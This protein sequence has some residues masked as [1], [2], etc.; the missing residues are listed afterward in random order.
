MRALSRRAPQRDHLVKQGSRTVRVFLVVREAVHEGDK[1][2]ADLLNCVACA[3]LLWLTIIQLEN[4]V[5][6]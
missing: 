1:T 6:A 5:K 3:A 4:P 2:D